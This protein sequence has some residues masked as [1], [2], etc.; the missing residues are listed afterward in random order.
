MKNCIWFYLD[1]HEQSRVSII[2][3]VPTEEP[4]YSS[5]QDGESSIVLGFNVAAKKPVKQIIKSCRSSLNS[6]SW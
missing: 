4:S 1:V 2:L 5:L 3:Y 6:L